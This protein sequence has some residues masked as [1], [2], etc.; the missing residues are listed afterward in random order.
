M[1]RTFRIALAVARDCN[2][3]SAQGWRAG[4]KDAA[5]ED[6]LSS[7]RECVDSASVLEYIVEVTVDVP[8]VPTVQGVVVQP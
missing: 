2:D 3:W 8:E 7:C 5:D 1:K 4:P 6:L